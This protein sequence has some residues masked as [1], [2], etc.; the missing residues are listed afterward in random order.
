MARV[1]FNGI[2]KEASLA[3]VA[4]VAVGDYVLVHVGFALQKLDEAEALEVFRYLDE[5]GEIEAEL[6]ARDGLADTPE[7]KAGDAP[8]GGVGDSAG[9]DA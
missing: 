8:E 5:I 2:V 6:G 9:G 3:C 7:G 1:S 4:D